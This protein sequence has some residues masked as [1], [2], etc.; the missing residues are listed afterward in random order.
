M[1]KQKKDNRVQALYSKH[2]NHIPVNIMN[3]TKI[4]KAIEEILATN[5]TDTDMDAKMASLVEQYRAE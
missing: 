3:L 4:H 2:F 1:K 5:T